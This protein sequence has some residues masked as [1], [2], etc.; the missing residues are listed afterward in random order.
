MQNVVWGQGFH[1]HLKEIQ[2]LKRAESHNSRQFL[3]LS[4]YFCLFVCF[5]HTV[6]LARS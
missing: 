2:I 5:G 1:H 3:Y 4:T 6:R